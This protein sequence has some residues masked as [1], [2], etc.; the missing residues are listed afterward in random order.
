MNLQ[1][2]EKI[3][4]SR[5]YKKKRFKSSQHYRGWYYRNRKKVIISHQWHIDDPF[6]FW[7]KPIDES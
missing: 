1:D 2:F 3:M 7:F 5:G 4:I 6:T